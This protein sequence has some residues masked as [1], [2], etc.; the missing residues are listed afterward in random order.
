[1]VNFAIIAT[2]VIGRTKEKNP[3]TSAALVE[4]CPAQIPG[5]F[6]MPMVG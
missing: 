2:K 1:M 4:E 6:W 5:L 3:S